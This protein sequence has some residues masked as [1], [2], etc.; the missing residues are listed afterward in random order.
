VLFIIIHGAQVPAAVLNASRTSPSQ[1]GLT[2]KM[3]LQPATPP[4]L[5]TR[6]ATPVPTHPAHGTE[7]LPDAHTEAVRARRGRRGSAH[8]RSTVCRC[9]WAMRRRE[10]VNAT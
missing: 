7:A 5:L 3:S 4:A 2:M 1:S 8:A 6:S 9:A 10:S